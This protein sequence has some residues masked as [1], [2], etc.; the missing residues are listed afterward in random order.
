MQAVALSFCRARLLLAP[1][2]LPCLSSD[3]HHRLSL[4]ADAS[5]RSFTPLPVLCE[6]VCGS[7]PIFTLFCFVGSAAAN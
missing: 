1:L 7:S 2:A 5:G 3:M 6:S 4:W